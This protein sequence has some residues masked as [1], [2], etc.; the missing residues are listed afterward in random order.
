MLNKPKGYISDVDPNHPSPTVF[1]LVGGQTSLFAVGRL[2][3][4]SEGLILLTNDGEMANRLTHPRYGHEKEYEVYVIHRPD[5]KQLEIWRRGVVLEDGTRTLPAK[6]EVMS[7][8]GTGAW[9]KIIMHE[10]KKRQ[11]RKVGA[12][13]GL[14][15]S[16]LIRVRIGPLTLG[17][18]KTGEWRALTEKEIAGL[19]EYIN[20]RKSA[21]FEHS[22]PKMKKPTRPPK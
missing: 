16:K 11:I 22:H 4:D 12:T 10:G 14:P 19:Q 2:D 8:S 9:L 17:N 1:D 15:V 6:V 21:K 3:L 20:S 13:I 18:L 7:I 5:D